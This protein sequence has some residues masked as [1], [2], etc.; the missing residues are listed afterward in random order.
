MGDP[1]IG[2]VF[3]IA[4]VGGGS[5]S[6]LPV[7]RRYEGD[8]NSKIGNREGEGD[9]SPRPSRGIYCE[10]KS[11]LREENYPGGPRR[12]TFRS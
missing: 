8:L 1:G 7:W 12:E 11:T 2:S 6:T 4:V 5:G 3:S 10:T 9:I